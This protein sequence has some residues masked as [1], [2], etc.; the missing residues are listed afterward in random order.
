MSVSENTG[1]QMTFQ[2]TIFEKKMGDELLSK[3]SYV[4]KDHT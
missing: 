4:E 3:S 1:H 2:I